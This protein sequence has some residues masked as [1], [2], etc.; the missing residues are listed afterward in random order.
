[1]PSCTSLWTFDALF[2]TRAPIPALHADA[3]SLSPIMQLIH[4][5][6]HRVSH[7]HSPYRIDSPSDDAPSDDKADQQVGSKAVYHQSAGD[8]LIWLLDIHLIAGRLSADDWRKL[9]SICREKRI[10]AVVADTLDATTDAFGLNVD[11]DIRIALASAVKEPSRA[12]LK[13][14]RIG[15]WYAEITGLPRWRDRLQL[16]LEHLLPPPAYM[17]QRYPGR[18]LLWL[19][20]LY[21]WRIVRGLIG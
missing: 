21:P 3:Y 15:N 10:C 12:L 13:V 7:F 9:V 14:G 6:L 11:G 2:A 19:P 8:R 20:L 5:C 1:M 16:L 17:L 4:A 18:S